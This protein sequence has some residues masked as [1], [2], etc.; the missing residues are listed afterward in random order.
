MGSVHLPVL[1]E[2][3]VAGFSAPGAVAA[4]HQLAQVLEP[5][6]AMQVR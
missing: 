5:T 6:E 1:R 4:V 3:I 2:T